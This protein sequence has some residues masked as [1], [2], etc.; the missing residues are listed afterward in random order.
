MHKKYLGLAAAAVISAALAGG[1]GGGGGSAADYT[2]PVLPGSGETHKTESFS[3]DGFVNS[4]ADEE[5]ALV[6]V[7]GNCKKLHDTKA[8]DYSITDNHTDEEDSSSD[9]GKS[10]KV[11]PEE[12]SETLSI[13]RCGMQQSITA[14]DNYRS[15]VSAGRVPLPESKIDPP[16]KPVARFD[17]K[18]AGFIGV[19][20]YPC[21]F[22]GTTAAVRE[23]KVVKMLGDDYTVHCNILS[24]A[25]DND[26]PMY[27]DA[28][29]RMV[30][31]AFDYQNPFDPEEAW[32]IGIYDRISGIFGFEWRYNPVGGRDGDERVNIV[33][34][35]SDAMNGMNGMVRYEDIYVKGIAPYS[36]E[37]EFIYLNIDNLR[38]FNDE[39]RGNASLLG[40]L[41]HQ[42]LHLVQLN[43]KVILEGQF[44]RYKP[45]AIKD[46]AHYATDYWDCR[47]L[48]EGYAELA[49][50][51]CGFG[52]RNAA[53]G[54]E[55]YDGAEIYSFDSISKYYGNVSVVDG[56]STG[57]TQYPADFFNICLDPEA[58]PYGIGHLF[59]LH[60]L[61]E[62]GQ[63]K[64]AALVQSQD[65]GIN[66][67]QTVLGES[68]LQIFHHFGLAQ[69]CTGLNY[70]P[71]EFEIPFIKIGTVNYYRPR[72]VESMPI[73]QEILFRYSNEDA[74]DEEPI[75]DDVM[76]WCSIFNF[77]LPDGK[78]DTFD[79][80][81]RYP[82]N[83]AVNVIHVTKREKG[84]DNYYY[85]DKMY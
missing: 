4:G 70:C 58:E 48:S 84:G 62:Y 71:A 47:P 41:T 53:R 34:C 25:N 29:A 10:A 1:C 76:P 45:T 80:T 79:A 57:Y 36:N 14:F 67:L 12:D 77:V 82:K 63:D 8:Y 24:Q 9:S 22:S 40:E 69:A 83:G 81:V 38:G 55:Q 21:D 15:D 20:N 6:V 3:F 78:H 75:T 74:I 66:N 61:Q 52:V 31:K 37:G 17:G 54:Q 60:L 2:L 43:N 85:F 42:Y 26:E 65:F 73:P 50:T 33:L 59:A 32:N 68:P 44:G 49:A 39:A 35:N 51:L 72:L 18:E 27:S 46:G 56:S 23:M 13:D 5:L 64:I 28:L 30:A 11:T 7:T 19:M 16:E